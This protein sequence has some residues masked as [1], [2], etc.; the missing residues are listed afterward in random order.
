MHFFTSPE[1]RSD[2]LD[3]YAAEADSISV[4]FVLPDRTP[5]TLI[6]S[7]HV[8]FLETLMR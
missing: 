6:V 4:P 5:R 1:R 7:L 2:D 3:L 8:A